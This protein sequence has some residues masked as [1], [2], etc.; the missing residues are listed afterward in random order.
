LQ[1]IAGKSAAPLNLGGRKPRS[2]LIAEQS[3]NFLLYAGRCG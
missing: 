2:G 1:L 3:Q